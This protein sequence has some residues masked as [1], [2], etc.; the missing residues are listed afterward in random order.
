VGQ[1]D[2]WARIVDA[3]RTEGVDADEFE[4]A[5]FIFLKDSFPTLSP[6]S[7]GTDLGRDA[8]ALDGDGVIRLLATTAA[9]P[10]D[11]LRNGLRRMREEGL[12]VSEVVL[13]SSQPVSATRRRQLEAIAEELEARLVMVY[14]QRWL[15][16]ELYRHGDWRERLI[17][18]T[19]EPP[20]LTPV[21]ISLSDSHLP[22]VD[23][24]GRDDA[25]ERLRGGDRDLIVVGS[26][27]MGKT[28]LLAEIDDIVFVELHGEVA[29]MADDIR[30]LEPSA[31]V[32]DDAHDHL[33]TL[34][35]LRR[36]RQAGPPQ[37]QIIASTWPDTVEAVGN[38]LAEADELALPPLE[39]PENARILEDLGITNQLLVGDILDQSEGRPGWT[40]VLGELARQEGVR[41]V[42]TGDVLIEEVGRFSR[43]LARGSV[44]VDLLARIA[45]LGHVTDEELSK[46]AEEVGLPL[47]EAFEQ[48]KRLARHGLAEWSQRRWTVRPPRLGAALVAHHFFS[49]PPAASIDAVIAAWPEKTLAVANS[50]VSAALVGST[51]A[52]RAAQTL[53]HQLADERDLLGDESGELLYSY[54]LT[55]PQAA[56]WVIKYL[57]DMFPAGPPSP[58]LGRDEDL[59]ARLG[60]YRERA[61]WARAAAAAD[62]A[63]QKFALPE[64]FDLLARMAL[65]DDGP[66]NH[67][68]HPRRR[69]VEL[70]T[71]IGPHWGTDRELRRE[72][73]HC[74]VRVAQ[75]ADRDADELAS[76]LASA[77]MSPQGRG[78]W[79]DPV[80]RYR[81]T[82]VD[83]LE[84]AEQLEWIAESLWPVWSEVVD[85]LSDIAVSRILELVRAWQR[86]AAD[87]ASRLEPT[88][89]VM[90]VARRHSTEMLRA[91][92]DRCQR[93]PGLATAWN[94]WLQDLPEADDLD[95]I[96]VDEGFSA[97][98]PDLELN[99]RER[100]DDRRQRI[101]Q[102]ADDLNGLGPHEIADRV[103]RWSA[104]AEAA[105]QHVGLSIARLL[106]ELGGR[107][108]P[109]EL[110]LEVLAREELLQHA[111]AL[112]STALESEP[113]RWQEWVP[114]GLHD[115]QQRGLVTSVVLAVPS[116]PDDAIAH[117]LNGLDATDAWRLEQILLRRGEADTVAEALLTH[118]DP[119]V[120]AA[121]ALEFG[122]GDMRYGLDLPDDWYT[123]WRDAFLETPAGLSG[124][125]AW[126]FGE[127]AEAL[128]DIDPDLLT[129]WFL[130]SL[131]DSAL[132]L[133]HDTIELVRYL[134]LEHR[135]RV[136]T[137][138]VDHPARRWL[139]CA[140]I[141]HDP[142]SV[143][144]L[145]DANV[146]DVDD[147]LLCIERDHR[148]AWFETVAPELVRRGA[149]P[150]DVATHLRFGTG[151]GH[152][153][154]L[155]TTLAEY[156]AGLVESE[157]P[158]LAEVGR[159][160][161][162]AFREAAARAAEKERED[163]I[164]GR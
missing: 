85:D 12:P 162:A 139:I 126:R 4:T 88:E 130:K 72:A 3:L 65:Q 19:G 115:P 158:E 151:W 11:N 77:A 73:L 142:D 18:V 74:A 35:L 120:R 30:R 134:P 56:L 50:I 83:R 164:R 152:E 91:I 52:H 138:A 150:R 87:T 34:D 137:A 57:A 154:Q 75:A 128:A 61:R 110:V 36:I 63:A 31:V 53:L 71:R 149:D 119:A 131:D 90:K 92:R 27:G 124:H 141:G 103:S 144:A 41:R 159:V 40:L 9:D 44:A 114:A 32:V 49:E 109:T 121:T 156:L 62:A 117:T 163:R 1:P 93:S 7:G 67:S 22:A 107:G 102:L 147:V 46:L 101:A 17:G 47:A 105:G 122:L 24:V 59:L 45:A 106:E 133:S 42:L 113:D 70:P 25:L 140:A 111:Y 100:E 129:E 16:G 157:V 155:Y 97:L 81:F 94:D 68:D 58:P 79:L 38:H 160:G 55:S 104:S 108:T 123:R 125:H 6:V 80:D 127:I 60:I 143:S 51:A 86:L 39:R 10:R 37:F 66:T 118:K 5:A 146:V 76:E 28:R 48:L 132:Q 15:A 89:E 29:R 23:L 26:S 69:L 99:W 116:A 2:L 161:E 96:E 54:A 95:P 145:L 13:A 64:A 153:S 33:E 82:W 135:R 43:R 136:L 112:A 98:V 148:G 20:A 84:D 8:D 78:S 21:P 14:D